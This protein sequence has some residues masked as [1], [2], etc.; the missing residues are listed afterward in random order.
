MSEAPSPNL[1]EM[2][3]WCKSCTSLPWR[4]R[5]SVYQGQGHQHASLSG[6]VLSVQNVGLNV[7][8]MDVVMPSSVCPPRAGDKR[9]SEHQGHASRHPTLT[10]PW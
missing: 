7:K 2:A 3:C 10:W 9:G 6:F 5:V 1:Y 8:V 4:Q